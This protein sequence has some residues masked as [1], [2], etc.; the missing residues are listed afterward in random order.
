MFDFAFLRSVP[1]I[2]HDLDVLLPR[3]QLTVRAP[4]GTPAADGG[5]AI[6]GD[7]ATTATLAGTGRTRAIT[8][9]LGGRYDV[10]GLAYLPPQDAEA[11]GA[12][13]DYAVLVSDDGEHFTRVTSG[14]WATDGSAQFA[15]WP[16]HAAR[17]L[18]L[19]AT[20]DAKTPLAAAELHVGTIR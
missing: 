16:Q 12:V 15:T 3:A 19:E 13:A 8:L 14:R 2:P 17:Y 9:D 10:A 1:A 5:R 18:R 20:T 11:T 7:C 6:D 4:D